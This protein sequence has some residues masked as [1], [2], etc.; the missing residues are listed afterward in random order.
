MSTGRVASSLLPLR[1]GPQESEAGLTSRADEVVVTGDADAADRLKACTG[2]SR[3]LRQIEQAA[4]GTVLVLLTCSDQVCSM[5]SPQHD[6]NC[7]SLCP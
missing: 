2:V 4:A 1:Q 5:R 7:S 6:F 3:D